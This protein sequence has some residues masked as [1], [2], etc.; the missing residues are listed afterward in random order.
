MRLRAVLNRD[1]GTLKTADLEAL[2]TAI[3][4]GFTA[5]GHVIDYDIVTGAMIGDALEIAFSEPSVD[6]VIA[7]GGD[8]TVS[9]AAALAWKH[10]KALGVL[11]AGTMNLFAR[12]LAIPL[13]LNAAIAALAEGKIADADIATANDRPFI[14]QFSLGIQP[15]M[16]VEREKLDHRSR[17]GKILAI[18]RASL[19]PLLRPPAFRVEIALDGTTEEHKVS[20]LAISTNPHGV[21]LLPIAESIDAGVLGVYRIDRLAMRQAF[22]VAIGF[23]HGRWRNRD[24]LNV[25]RVRSVILRFPEIKPGARASIDG[26]LT[27]LHEYIEFRLHPGALKVLVPQ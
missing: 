6:G 18:A 14:H 5:C 25:C 3:V 21:T 24:T 26:E 1:G 13:E 19:S 15:R 2:T 16:V 20:M 23:L 27:E 4:S 8:G 17:S 22:K 9:A 10:E 11:P 12:T 7:G